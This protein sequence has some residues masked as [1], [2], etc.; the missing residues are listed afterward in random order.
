MAN[1]LLPDCLTCPTSRPSHALWHRVIDDQFGP[2]LTQTF[3]ASLSPQ[4]IAQIEPFEP[5]TVMM[6]IR[7]VPFIPLAMLP[8]REF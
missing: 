2:A 4:C 5:L 6:T 3:S 1:R 8:G 7:Q